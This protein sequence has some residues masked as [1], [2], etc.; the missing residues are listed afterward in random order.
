MRRHVLK[1]AET[2]FEDGKMWRKG[3]VMSKLCDKI[4]ILTA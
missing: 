1:L 4:L 2:V 3:L